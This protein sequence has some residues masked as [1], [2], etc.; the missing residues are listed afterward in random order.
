ME[1]LSLSANRR[2][3]SESHNFIQLVVKESL[4]FL[5]SI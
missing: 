2:V 4:E 3:S 1:I 5:K